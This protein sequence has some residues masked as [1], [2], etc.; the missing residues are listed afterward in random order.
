MQVIA[1]WV[2]YKSVGTKDTIM[3]K[4]KQVK[5]TKMMG[6]NS[7]ITQKIKFPKKYYNYYN[8]NNNNSV[9]FLNAILTYFEC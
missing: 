4:T 1:L 3:Q 7:C 8:N 5:H 6:N 9:K 2:N